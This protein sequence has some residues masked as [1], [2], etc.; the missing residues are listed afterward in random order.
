MTEPPAGATTLLRDSPMTAL[1]ITTVGICLLINLIDGFDVMAIAFAAPELAR[2]WNLSPAALG[3]VFSAGVAGMTGASILLAPVADYIGRRATILMGLGVVTLS[4]AASAIA[5]APEALAIFRFCTGL[6]VGVLL[7]SLNTMVAEFASDRRRELAVAIMQ[8][9]FPLGAVLGGFAALFLQSSFGWQ[10]VFWAGALL[11]G[12][13]IPLVLLWLPESLDFLL[14]RRDS[15]ALTRVNALLARL[16]RNPL[17]ALPTP[18]TADA[19]RGYAVLGDPRVATRL[20]AL[21]A[22]FFFQLAAFYFVTSWTPKLLV[23]GGL[24]ATTGISGGIL[25]NVAGATGGVLLGWAAWRFGARPLTVGFMLFTCVSMFLFPWAQSLAAMLTMA[26]LMGFF[27]VGGMMG[28]YSLTPA[29]FPPGMRATATGLAVGFGRFGAIL[30]PLATGFLLE[31]GWAPREVYQ[32]F[33]LPP[34]VA[35]AA[36]WVLHRR[37]VSE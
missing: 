12:V 37:L 22:A 3:I 19:G 11:S 14:S 23:D 36:L 1:Q 27:V 18:V 8:A 15:D 4:M 35:A 30:G 17:S 28:L 26:A 34:L 16:G 24:D 21:C 5:A 2:A 10:G 32:L 20:G 33:C 31:A 6:G 7:P 29:L 13:M 9:G 25:L